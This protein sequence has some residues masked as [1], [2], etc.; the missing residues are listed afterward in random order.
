VSAPTEPLAI[1][2]E[3]QYL[4]RLARCAREAGATTLAEDAE[5]LTQ[6]VA[7][8]RVHVACVGQ[9]KRGKSTV[10][11][12]LIGEPVLPTGVVPITSAVTIVRQGPTRTARVHHL[13]HSFED[14]RVDQLAEYVTESGN[15]ANAKGVAAVEVFLPSPFLSGGL[16]LVD[17]PGVGSTS[18]LSTQVTRS[19]VPQ[20]DAALVVLGA[21][22]PIAGQEVQLLDELSAEARDLV[23][24]INKADKIGDAELVDV[25]VFTE[26]LLIDRFGVVPDS[27]FVVSAA[28]RLA[29]NAPTRDWARLEQKLRSLADVGHGRW[30]LARVQAAARR[31]GRQLL[32]SIDAS[33]RAVAQP[34]AE[35]ERQLAAL[36]AWL[37]E[38][39]QALRDFGLLLTAEQ[40][41]IARTLRDNITAQTAEV[42]RSTT[43]DLHAAI[44][45]LGD[46]RTATRRTAFE[47]AQ[48]IARRAV[49]SELGV[50]EH[51]AAD[52]YQQ[53]TSRFVA[54]ANAFL[55]RLADA[56]P[57][58]AALPP[59]E[60]PSG[61][62]GR[63]RFYFTE[64]MTLTA[65]HPF[66]W[67]FDAIAPRAARRKQLN[68]R[69]QA[70]LERLVE[71]NTSRVISDLEERLAE[72]RHELE[73]EIRGRLTELVSA[74]ER[75]LARAV[76]LRDA[77]DL[78]LQ[79]ERH[80][81]AELRRQVESLAN[82]RVPELVEPEAQH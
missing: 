28:E 41:T 35:N 81:L 32:Q 51:R 71:T 53:A 27:L 73:R 55:S 8:G 77:G 36:R 76:E 42:V 63:R 62:G 54:L 21:D 66:D 38:A 25:L 14:I 9:F 78:A 70:Y 22:P 37:S 39:Q 72:S 23:F 5:A 44:D 3:A 10:L 64:L 68:E 30:F 33:M 82:S 29:E 60:S 80:R 17:T 69:A 7:E 6:R 16:C 43:R 61:L 24:A 4:Q 2:E 13:D 49:Q 15:P 31:I 59:I 65:T 1:P 56:Q 18:P 34:V 46:S 12:A 48:A 40:Q 58:L 47:R 67:A 26:R 52:V 45:E 20:V 11:N 19:F 75:S 74:A 79:A 57:S 50:M